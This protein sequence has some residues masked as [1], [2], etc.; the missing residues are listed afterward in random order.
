M[1]T[2]AVGRAARLRECNDPGSDI[3]NTSNLS[4]HAKYM[5]LTCARAPGATVA[6]EQSGEAFISLRATFSNRPDEKR[7]ERRSTVTPLVWPSWLPYLI[8]LGSAG[9][10]Q[11]R[12]RPGRAKPHGRPRE[13]GRHPLHPPGRHLRRPLQALLRRRPRPARPRRPPRR[14]RPDRRL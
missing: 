4:F 6:R 14:A 9:A 8:D 11:R 12:R 2:A 3:Q 1:V 10:L 7:R 5:W 13:Q